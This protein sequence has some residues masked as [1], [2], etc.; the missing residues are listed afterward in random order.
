VK[1]R[2]WI[3]AIIL[4]AAVILALVNIGG[5]DDLI[6]VIGRSKWEWLLLGLGLQMITFVF[7]AAVWWVVLREAGAGYSLW[8]LISLGV[9]K[10]FTDQAI[11]T[12]GLSGA[13]YVAAALERRGVPLPVCMAAMVMG[14]IGYY[15]SFLLAAFLGIY[16]LW[17]LEALQSWV[18]IL[19]LLFFFLAVGIP[20]CVILVQRL[21]KRSIPA[22]LGRIPLLRTLVKAFAEAPMGLVF[23]P[24]LVLLAF[25]FN[26]AVFFLDVATMWAMLR[27]IGQPVS[28]WFAFPP[29]VMGCVAAALGIVPMGL[30][31]FETACILVLFALGVP[32]GGSVAAT[33]LV[34]GYILWLPM[35]PGLWL[36][37]RELVR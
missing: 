15:S 27:A 21:S 19:T 7:V 12:A 13:A 37:K 1:A 36:T 28:Y 17:H 25:L 18:S 8:S 5:L 32:W 31:T 11:P 10:H 22:W 6:K 9:A 3:F 20:L 2:I 35:L 26:L 24:R 23:K 14:M 16:I 33:L 4:G 29:Y 30:G 34:R